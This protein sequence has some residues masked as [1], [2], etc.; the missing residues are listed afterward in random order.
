MH[1]LPIY[2]LYLSTVLSIYRSLSLSSGCRFSHTECCGNV[3]VAI[4]VFFRAQF[5]TDQSRDLSAEWIECDTVLHAKGAFFFFFFFSLCGCVCVCVCLRCLLG[6][7]SS[8]LCLFF[9]GCT[10]CL[11]R[12]RM[13]SRTTLCPQCFSPHLKLFSLALPHLCS[14]VVVS[15]YFF[16]L[17]LSSDEKDPRHRR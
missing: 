13:N 14:F 15:F 6:R 16:P 10:L 7:F 1:T 3:I 9:Y 8:S 2:L 4:S 11:L 12:F 17:L 5:E